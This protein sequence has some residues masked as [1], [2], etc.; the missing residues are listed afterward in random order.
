M[1][2]YK[3]GF[4]TGP[5]GNRNGIGDY[6]KALDSDG[7]PASLISVDDYGPCYELDN[8]ARASGV[9]HVNVYR[10]N[11]KIPGFNPDVPRYDLD[12]V[13]AAQLWWDT[14]YLYL[15]PEFLAGD[16]RDRV[17]LIAGNEVDKNRSNWLGYWALA[18]ATLANADGF[19]IAAFGFS[20]G[21]PEY[22]DWD[23]PGMIAYLQYCNLHPEIAGVALHE[24]S[25][26]L[27]LQ[28]GWGYK[29]GRFLFLSDACDR[30][31]IATPKIFVTEFGWTYQ[32]VPSPTEAVAQLWSA[33]D[34]YANAPE[35]EGA[36]IWYLG[37]GYADIAN[38]AQKLIVP[39]TESALQYGWEPPEEPPPPPPPQEGEMIDLAEYFCPEPGKSHGP[40]YMLTNNWGQG[41]ERTHLAVSPTG[42]VRHFYVTKNSRWERRWVGKDWVFLQADTSHSDSTFYTV[43]GTPWLPRYMTPGD[44]YQRSE[45]IKI[46]DID[47]CAFKQSS[48][49]TSDIKLVGYDYDL[50]AEFGFPVVHLQWLIDGQ[51]EE[52]YWY[53]QYVGLV[54]WRKYTGFES[55]LSEFVP[56]TEQP[57]KVE[58]KCTLLDETTPSNIPE[59]P[60]PPPTDSLEKQAWDKT[61]DMQVT[62][63]NGIRLNAKAGIQQRIEE[64][65][66]RYGLAL[67]IVTSEITIEG[68]VYQ[69]AESR[70]GACSRRVYH[71][72]PGEEITFFEDPN[73]VF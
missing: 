71:W 23:E 64:D 48:G 69:A 40:I 65:S 46:Y 29:I 38:K 67:Q 5:G 36:M 58:W 11:D 41:P 10:V 68:H 25:Y 19:K 16:A 73:L 35:I 57:N 62:G 53:G 28:D 24:Y 7:I 14:M 6:W 15:P 34:L 32:E 59:P 21:E 27:N 8:I 61:V 72:F 55:K 4:H 22:D 18:V 56:V 31:G 37:P 66:Q 52:D 45:S 1:T 13:L 50:M 51:V 20:S 17:W 54:R 30:L 12:P 44:V 47:T 43:T 3:I 70:T 2:H 60:N 9:P 26:T 63:N 49:M 42:S 33:A 39:V